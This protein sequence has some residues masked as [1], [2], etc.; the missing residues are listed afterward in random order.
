MEFYPT[1]AIA[2]SFTRWLGGTRVSR[3]AAWRLVLRST[4]AEPNPAGGEWDDKCHSGDDQDQ[5]K[6]EGSG[7][8]AAKAW[9]PWEDVD[10]EG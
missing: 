4:T 7:C 5:R 10:D 2:G 1:L 8:K 3:R 9:E 6:K